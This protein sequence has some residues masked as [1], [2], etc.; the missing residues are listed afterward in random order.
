MPAKAELGQAVNHSVDLLA[1]SGKLLLGAFVLRASLERQ[2]RALDTQFRLQLRQRFRGEDVAAQFEQDGL[3]KHRLW[4]AFT[5]AITGVSVARADV[6]SPGDM[7]LIRADHMPIEQRTTAQAEGQP[8]QDEAA[9]G[10]ARVHLEPSLVLYLLPQL[11]GD[12]RIA[13]IG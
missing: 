11:F 12:D 7:L 2:L 10:A 6:V 8:G 5:W 9:P 13:V 1:Q 3:F 4:D